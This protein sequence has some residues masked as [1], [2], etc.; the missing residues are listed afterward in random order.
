MWFFTVRVSVRRVTMRGVAA[1]AA[2]AMFDVYPALTR[3]AHPIP[4]FGLAPKNRR[5]TYDKAMLCQR[6][7]AVFELMKN[8]HSFQNV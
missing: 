1:D 7:K 8:G 3:R 4:P 2:L 6:S 5:I